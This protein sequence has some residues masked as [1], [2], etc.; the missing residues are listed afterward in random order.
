MLKYSAHYIYQDAQ[1]LLKHHV[2]TISDEGVIVE[3][4]PL[5]FET[6]NTRFING[7]IVPK[8]SE[9]LVVEEG[10][11]LCKT[12]EDILQNYANKFRLRMAYN[13]DTLA[14]FSKVQTLDPRFSLG[15]LWKMVCPH[16]RLVVGEKADLLFLENVDLKRLTFV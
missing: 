11:I 10:M 14:I 2:M 8:P 13:S 1:I 4:S 7:I 15:D 12:V 16:K 9:N 5:T 6:A 3:I